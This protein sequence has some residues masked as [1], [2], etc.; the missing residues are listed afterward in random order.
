MTTTS[1]LYTRKEFGVGRTRVITTLSQLQPSVGP[2]TCVVPVRDPLRSRV[3]PPCTLRTP[4]Q[5]IQ[6]GWGCQGVHT[7]QLSRLLRTTSS[8]SL[9]EESKRSTQGS[10]S[11]QPRLERLTW[12]FRSRHERKR[13]GNSVA[14]DGNSK[15][16]RSRRG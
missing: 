2:V 13:T 5:W 11:D 14:R 10:A 1:P 4:V 9:E 16:S 15:V 6:G 7:E 12:N 8:L 3:R